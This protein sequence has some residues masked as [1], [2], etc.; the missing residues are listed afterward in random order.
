MSIYK[1]SYFRLEYENRKLVKKVALGSLLIGE[2]NYSKHINNLD[3]YGRKN[4]IKAVTGM[5]E[6]L[7]IQVD[8]FVVKNCFNFQTF[9]AYVKKGWEMVSSESI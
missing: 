2:L 6:M 9:K 3:R 1:V 5:D 7:S 4:G 8:E